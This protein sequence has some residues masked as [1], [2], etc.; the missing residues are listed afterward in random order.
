MQNHAG[1]RTLKNDP[2]RL[3]PC[4]I[5]L[6]IGCTSEAPQAAKEAL[7]RTSP[8][9]EALAPKIKATTQGTPAATSP[10]P[11]GSPQGQ[12]T[13]RQKHAQG[14]ER[15]IK[16]FC[17]RCHSFPDPADFTMQTWGP[18]IQFM[19]RYFEKYKI[20]LQG[21]PPPDITMQYYARRAAR[22]IQTPSFEPSET[23]AVGIARSKIRTAKALNAIADVRG[24]RR[25]DGFGGDVLVSNML[26]GEISAFTTSQPDGAPK[27]LAKVNHPARLTTADLDA[28]GKLDIIVGELGTF[29][30]D[31]HD[32]GKAVW[33]RQVK[34]GK[35]KAHNLTE[36]MGRVAEIAAGR[37]DGNK[38]PD[39]VVAEFGWLNTGSLSLV[40]NPGRSKSGPA[41]AIK[42]DSGRGATS[43]QIGDLNGDGHQDIVALFGQ[44][45]E[46]VIA[47]F[48]DS[49]GNFTDQT[50]YRAATPLWGATRIRLVD[51]DQD[52]DLD[53]LVANGDT[54]D[55][56]RIAAFQG[57]HLLTNTGGKTFEHRQLLALPGVQD[58]QALDYDKDGDLDIVAVSS[59]PPS[60]VRIAQKS[61]PAAR[62][63]A[64]AMLLRQEAKGEYT[65]YTL[66]DD[67][68]CY[69]SIA[70][71]PG[72]DT[73]LYVG[74]FGSQSRSRKLHAH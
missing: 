28:D 39:I 49:K 32:R 54:L 68:P 69:S 47:Y 71:T 37:L 8:K 43:V 3:W 26:T 67:A 4:I 25:K 51:L 38:Y 7:S 34:R 13:P 14:V 42:L 66:A 45:R 50:I 21:A 73:A 33:L 53:I 10:T 57:I 11:V 63:L 15:G 61:L 6:A 19:Y 60:I 72:K 2:T 41:K 55:A 70:L 5:L 56:P 74:Q 1:M 62:V 52:K 59:L 9:P 30:A 20:D 23:M 22:T 40:L 16:L 12:L 48:G 17:G 35:F 36:G 29:G 24:V 64:S 46:E 31:D 44:E 27:V 65:P 18:A 58:F